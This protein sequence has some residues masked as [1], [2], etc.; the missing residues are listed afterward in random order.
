MMAPYA[1][2]FQLEAAASPCG[3]HQLLVVVQQ[4]EYSGEKGLM[5]NASQPS[6]TLLARPTQLFNKVQ[7]EEYPQD[8]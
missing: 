8:A 1:P 6:L 5:G 7:Q 2:P 3:Q 4:E